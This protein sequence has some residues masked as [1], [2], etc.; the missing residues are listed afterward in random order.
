MTIGEVSGHL[1]ADWIPSLPVAVG[2]SFMGWP[3]FLLDAAR[4]NGQDLMVVRAEAG[5]SER[6]WKS[7]LSWMLGVAGAR[8]VLDSEGYRWVAPVSAFY[9]GAVQPVDLSAWNPV[10][11]PSVVTT[12]RNAGNR[13]RLCPDYLALRPVPATRPDRIY[14]WAVAEAKGTRRCLTNLQTCP[15]AWSNQARNLVV[16]VAGSTLTIPRHLVIATRVNPNAA[17]APTR[18]I[19]LRAWN[20]KKKTEEMHLPSELAIEIASAHLFGLFEGLGLR[21]NARAVALSVQARAD[22]R[23]GRVQ[24]STRDDAERQSKL[25]DDELRPYTRK[26]ELVAGIQIAAEIP[27]QSAPGTIRVDL[28]DPLIT[29]ARKLSQTEDPDAVAAALRQVDS[30]LDVWQTSRRS[31]T[32]DAGRVVLPSGVEL[33]LPREF[34]S[35]R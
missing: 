31:A 35:R 34:E 5:R 8:H 4:I 18:R 23:A 29:L 14:E 30:Q 3:P 12:T 32:R 33:L 7:F 15:L 20:R 10:F 24:P 21:E 26:R 22:R 13:S 16:R 1:L 19:Q 17:N 11:P 27:I 28:A 6:Q 2:P 9:A 25:A